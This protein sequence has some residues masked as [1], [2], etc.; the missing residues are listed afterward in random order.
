MKARKKIRKMIRNR[1]I[2][3]LRRMIRYTL[4]NT[5]LANYGYK[6][7]IKFEITIKIL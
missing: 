3:E 2:K 7:K 5:L 6:I 4:K 1:R